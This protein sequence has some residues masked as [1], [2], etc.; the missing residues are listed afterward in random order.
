MAPTYDFERAAEQ[1][2]GLKRKR[3]ELNVV[4]DEQR[5]TAQKI[6]AIMDDAI[7]NIGSSF[8]LQVTNALL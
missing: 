2:A 1:A 7:T 5:H 8:S 4:L 3:E 6:Y